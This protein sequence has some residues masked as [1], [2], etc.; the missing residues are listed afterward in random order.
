MAVRNDLQLKERLSIAINN[1]KKKR[2]SGM[3]RKPSSLRITNFRGSRG[4]WLI[5]R[6]IPWNRGFLSTIID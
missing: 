2:F 1:F 6:L 4:T 3:K 5:W